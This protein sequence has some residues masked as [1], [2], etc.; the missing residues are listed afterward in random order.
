M[1]PRLT[2]ANRTMPVAT[3]AAPARTSSHHVGQLPIPEPALQLASID[4]AEHQDHAVLVDDVVHHAVVA[5][6]QSVEGIVGATDGL[7]R[8]PGDAALTRDVMCE[9]LEGP[10]DAVAVGVG[11]LL[12]LADRRT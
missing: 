3:A 6:A 1:T 8:L 12:E 7:D 10:A 9:S 2:L 11:E 4:D 5:D